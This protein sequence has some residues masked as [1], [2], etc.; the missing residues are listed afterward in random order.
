MTHQLHTA[1]IDWQTDHAGNTVPVSTQFDDVYF[2]KTGGFAETNYVFL[3]G[4]NL[5]ERFA[6]LTANE[7]FVIGETGFGTGLNFIATCLLWQQVAQKTLAC[8]LS[9]PK[10]FR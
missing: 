4:N 7:R 3:Q 8:I 1:H 10:N 5:P 6:N 2:S 9:V